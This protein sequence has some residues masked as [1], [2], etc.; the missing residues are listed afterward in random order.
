MTQGDELVIVGEVGKRKGCGPA[1]SCDRQVAGKFQRFHHRGELAGVRRPI[2]PA[3]PYVHRMD[4]ATAEQGQQFVASLFE[5]EPTLHGVGVVA[6]HRDA[7][8]IA[9]KV[10][11]VQHHDVQRVALDPLAAIEEPA[12]DAGRRVDHDPQRVLDGV[13]AA[14]LVG[15]RTDPADP[16]DDVEHLA[17]PASAQ[18]RLEK[19]RRLENA[20]ADT[21]DL[22][23]ANSQIQRA[24][25]FD[26]RDVIDS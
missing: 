23:V 15:D 20:E 22:A 26:P 19:S 6:G 24:F 17:E 13:H 18:Q 12:Q 3:D 10:G 2:E 21:F 9:E 16:R 5:R 11:G 4:R 1:Q 8:G 14:H 7:V 25:A